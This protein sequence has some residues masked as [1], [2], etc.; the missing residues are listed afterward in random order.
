[1]PNDLELLGRLTLAIRKVT[2]LLE[3]LNSIKA[4]VETSL[5]AV[6]PP[7]TPEPAD[8]PPVNEICVE[9]PE[10]KKLPRSFQDWLK[11]V[12]FKDGHQFLHRKTETPLTLEWDTKKKYGFLM[13][14]ELSIREQSLGTI[15]NAV[16][17]AC[18][19]KSGNG[20]HKQL[21][22]KHKDGKFYCI[23]DDI[24]GLEWDW[25][26]GL[27]FKKE[28]SVKQSAEDRRAEIRQRLEVLEAEYD[29]MNA[30]TPS[31]R[32]REVE[33]QIATLESE[34]SDLQPIKRC[35]ACRGQ[36]PGPDHRFCIVREYD[37]DIKRWEEG[38]YVEK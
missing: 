18:G 30:E 3:E 17:S 19:V 32:V 1:M 29:A 16:A 7:P 24:W 25:A 10:P 31:S 15:V 8:P 33:V 36:V 34:L 21:M 13:N 35:G 27:W 38:C 4:S 20:W 22:A 12:G 9:E 2:D 37:C 23:E 6:A 26:K 14:A 11:A 5:I 28:P